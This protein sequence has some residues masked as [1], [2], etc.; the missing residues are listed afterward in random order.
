MAKKSYI[1][2][3]WGEENWTQPTKERAQKDAEETVAE[4]CVHELENAHA[5]IVV[6]DGIEYN[7]KIKATLVRSR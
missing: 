2:I 6:I 4:F 1:S 7:L 5:G 3:Q